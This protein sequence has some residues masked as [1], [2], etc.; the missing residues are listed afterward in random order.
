M[1]DRN[2]TDKTNEVK[3]FWYV[4]R[5]K[6]GDEH[7]ANRNLLNQEIETF[8]PLFRG[9][10][11]RVGK[12]IQTIKPLFSNYLFAKLDIGVHYNKVKWT[13][14]VSRILGNREGP[15][16]ISE[17]VVQTIQERVGKD[18]LIELEDQIKEGDLVQITS[19]PLKDLI[20]VF[21]KKMSGKDRVKILLNLIGVDVPV[22]ISKYQIE[23]VV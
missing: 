1:S 15:I 6:A 12:M 22:Q 14:G 21:Q 4:V 5:T 18:D 11:Y 20:G 7:R 10:E 2:E 19:G 9:Y 13:R 23:K 3:K 8:L 17:K 16:P